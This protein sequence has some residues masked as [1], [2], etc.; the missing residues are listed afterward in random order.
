MILR[1]FQSSD[2]KPFR[3]YFHTFYTFNHQCQDI[4]GTFSSNFSASTTKWQITTK[5]SWRY[6]LPGN[7]RFFFSYSKSAT[8]ARSAESSHS[9]TATRG[10]NFKPQKLE[11]KISVPEIQTVQMNFPRF[12]LNP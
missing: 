3:S 4:N 12:P 10:L 6:R 1:V 2:S 5:A 7:E 11:K 8:S 9:K